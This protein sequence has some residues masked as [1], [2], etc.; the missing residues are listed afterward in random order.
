MKFLSA[1]LYL[2]SLDVLIMS[3]KFES[4]QNR[5]LRSSHFSVELSIALELFM[6]GFLGLVLLKLYHAA[7]LFKE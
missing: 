5:R 1:N 3:S 6:V 2:A 7:K 4:Y